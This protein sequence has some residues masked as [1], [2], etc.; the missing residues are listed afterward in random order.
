VTFSVTG[1][2]VESKARTSTLTGFERNSAVHEVAAGLNPLR[3]L[4][5]SPCSLTAFRA[6]ADGERGWGGDRG[7]A[8]GFERLR[9]MPARGR[10]RST[11]TRARGWSRARTRYQRRPQQLSASPETALIALRLR[12]C[13]LTR[14]KLLLSNI[15]RGAAYEGRGHRSVQVSGCCY[16][17]VVLS[18]ATVRNG[19]KRRPS[20]GG[21]RIIEG[22][23]TGPHCGAP[24][25]TA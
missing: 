7:L 9:R 14:S 17:S 13:S 11:S 18:R 4:N 21:R 12:S 20:V 22:L 1:A 24:R 19:M 10:D 5:A 2:R 3:G 16:L 8:L 25:F 6:G 23:G 15:R